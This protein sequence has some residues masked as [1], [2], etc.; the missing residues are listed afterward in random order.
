MRNIIYRILRKIFFSFSPIIRL[1]SKEIY[2]KY[3]A[4]LKLGYMSFDL[5]NPNTYNEKLNFR[6][7]HY[8]KKMYSI[9][10]NKLLVRDYVSKVIGKEYLVPMYK[11]SNA[12]DEKLISELPNRFV[13]KLSTGSGSKFIRIV[14]DKNLINW[15]KT[16]NEMNK[17]KK[18]KYGKTN[19]ELWY[20]ESEKFFIFEEYLGNQIN[21]PIEYKVYCFNNND[22][23]DFIVREIK[24][25]SQNKT[26][27]FYDSSWFNLNFSYNKSISHGISLKPVYFDDIVTISK[28][29]SR[30]FDHVR[31]DLMYYNNKL[32]FGEL[33]F[34][35]TSGFIDF[36]PK[37]YDMELGKKWIIRNELI[38]L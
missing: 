20:D 6:K 37:E 12:L 38:E 28:K 5:K 17:T 32:Y 33:T 21:S 11:H 2:L 35:D 30:P 29:L 26:S 15:K 14:E 27:S 13:L 16:I 18:I 25:R 9:Y 19:F 23:F 36:N 7:L 34:A 31:V 3:L 22:K 8:H 10:T 4:F 24:D 1:F